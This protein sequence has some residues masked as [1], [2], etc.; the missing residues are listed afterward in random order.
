MFMPE[1]DV[2]QLVTTQ[3]D[4]PDAEPNPSHYVSKLF[5]PNTRP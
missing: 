1:M 4:P 5:W 2:G 3:P